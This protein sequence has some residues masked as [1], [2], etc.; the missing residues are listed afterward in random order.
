MLCLDSSLP[1][2]ITVALREGTWS[3]VR[4]IKQVCE[5]WTGEGGGLLRGMWACGAERAERS[6]RGGGLLLRTQSVSRAHG[7]GEAA[8]SAVPE[9]SGL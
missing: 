6:C 3:P 4:N 8:L 7:P 2:E 9:S 5:L 1:W